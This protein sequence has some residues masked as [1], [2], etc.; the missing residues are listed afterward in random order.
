MTSDG[1]KDEDWDRVHELAVEIVNASE[2]E[3]LSRVYTQRLLTVLDELEEKYG[4][5][6]SILATRADYVDDLFESIDL[7]KRAFE[8]G[9]ARNDKTNL[10]YISSS[11]ASRYIQSLRDVN[12]GMEWLSVFRD[13]L[14]SCGD[15]SDHREY[16]ELSEAL[17]TLEAEAARPGDR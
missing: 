14:S 1:I 4:A 15:E 8:T 16:E 6:P 5:L 10:L 12:Q 9:T 13:R 3:R 7:L 2:D 11:L 17:R